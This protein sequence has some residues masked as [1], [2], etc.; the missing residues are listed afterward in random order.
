MPNI[1][2]GLS[3]RQRASLSFAV[4]CAILFSLVYFYSSSE[5]SKSFLALEEADAKT[6]VSRVHDA[7]V[8][9]EKA[10]ISSLIGYAQWDDAFK[11]I[12]DKNEAFEKSNFGNTL[13]TL[14]LEL[15]SYWGLKKNLIYGTSLNLTTEDETKVVYPMSKQDEIKLQSIEVFHQNKDLGIHRALF[16]ELS[17]GPC[18]AITIPVSTSDSKTPANGVLIA[19]KKM[20]EDYFSNLGKKLHLE[21]KAFNLQGQSTTINK[22]EIISQLNKSNFF[23]DRISNNELEAY[24]MIKDFD[25]KE[26]VLFKILIPRNIYLQS[27]ETLQTFLYTIIFSTIALIIAILFLMNHLVLAKLFKLSSVIHNIM[28]TG[29][30][31]EKVPD[32][33][34]DEI[35]QLGESFNSMVNEI[36]KLKANAIHNEKMVSR[37]E[38]SGGIAHEINNPI[39][40]INVSANLMKLMH[41]KGITEPEKYLKQ[42]DT[43]TETV[44]RISHIITG[45]K[46]I[47]RDV[48]EEGFIKCSLKEIL[49]DA[50]GVCGEKFKVSGVKI[51]INL[52][53]P[54]YQTSVNC[55][56]LQMSQVFINLF[57]NAFDANEK[58]NDPWVEIS[59][60]KSSD[61]ILVIKVK[62]SGLGIP[63]EIQSKIFQPFFTTKEIGRGSGLGL[64]L[65]NSI[66]QHHGGTLSIDNNSVNTCFLI[67]LP[68]QGKSHE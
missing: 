24:S 40:I 33:G 38:M 31:N 16:I 60:E 8:G 55:L 12:N 67:K 10:Y 57:T 53:D 30:L 56:R 61:D 2:S 25:S 42:I 44:T 52:N 58:T 27:Q 65:C 62:D 6:N 19:A 46:N 7:I 59:A 64:S 37:G 21:I 5:I 48:S 14:N 50:I 13:A 51:N 15:F 54:I 18:F 26:F 43:I 66:V 9:D 35:G 1:M 47:S 34:G 29:S 17:E 39:S 20:N 45:L 28:K 68:L 3:L 22:M 11:Y 23:I 4:I 32:L 41:Q 49:E 36:D 63:K